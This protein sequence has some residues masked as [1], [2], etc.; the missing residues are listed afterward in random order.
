M[1]VFTD[2]P[3]T[4][5]EDLYGEG[6]RRAVEELKKAVEV[7]SFAAVVGPRRVG[8]TSV[9]KSFLF[10]FKYPYLYFDFSPYMGQTAVSFR[11]LVPAGVGFDEKQLSSEAQI[12]LAVV[13]LR[14][15][16]V[17]I[18][19]DVFEANLLSLLREL[20]ERFRRFILVFD[21]AQ[22]LAFLK[23]V[24][25][26]GLLQFVHNNFENIVV[27]LTGSMPG[28]L[29]KVISPADA[30]VAGFARYVE[31][32]GIPRWN[33][34]ETAGFLEEGLRSA[35]IGFEQKDLLE[36]HE[37]LS[38][39]PGF[40]SYYGL[41]RVKGNSHSSSLKSAMDYAM[42]Q[43]RHDLQA[44]TAV[45]KSPIYLGLLRFLADTVTGASWSEIKHGLKARLGRELPNPM[46]LRLLRNLINAGMVEKRDDRYWIPDYPLR[47]ALLSSIS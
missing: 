28:L 8:K 18:T 39:I 26:R 33:A 32:I 17:R 42:A 21:E 12:Y 46:L 25:G 34:E 6:H 43:W 45:Y 47:R 22:V 19:G 9:V 40:I 36:V 31:L 44:F 10:H 41:L 29:E 15:K 37:K 2:R 1:V 27:V 13:C 38:G 30:R 4:R 7:R 3:I 16:R 23:G 11:S 20:N 5:V 24:N 35:K 14:V